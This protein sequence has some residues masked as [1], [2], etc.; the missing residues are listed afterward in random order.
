MNPTRTLTLAQSRL[1][2]DQRKADGRIIGKEMTTEKRT[3]L[4][5]QTPVLFP[6]TFIISSIFEI[7]KQHPFD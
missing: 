3:E 4:F 6:P 5:P 7:A 2:T 1:R